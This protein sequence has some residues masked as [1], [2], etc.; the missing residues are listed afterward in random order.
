MSI[1][2]Q[3]K[4]CSDIGSSACAQRPLREVQRSLESLKQVV[5]DVDEEVGSE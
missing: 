5:G 2:P 4:S 3:G 1:I